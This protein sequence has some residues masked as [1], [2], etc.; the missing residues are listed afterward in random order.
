MINGS[1]TNLDTLQIDYLYD[2]NGVPYGG[3]Y[4]SPTDTGSPLFFAM[5]T[6][7]RSDVV[8][9]LDANGHPFAGY[10]YDA[11]GNPTGTSLISDVIT[12]GL[13]AAIANRQ[14]LRYASYVYDS[15]SGLYYLSARS[16]DPATAQF[17]SPDLAKADGEESAYQ[18]CG[19]EP[20]G[21]VDPTG[22]KGE[23]FAP[24]YFYDNTAYFKLV[25]RRDA[26]HA[27]LAL[28]YWGSLWWEYPGHQWDYKL[29]YG[30]TAAR[31]YTDCWYFLG[32]WISPDDFGNIHFGYICAEMWWPES[33][34][35]WFSKKENKHMPAWKEKQDEDFIR[36]GYQLH[37]YWGSD[38][39]WRWWHVQ[40]Y[41]P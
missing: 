12:P 1:P 40:Y 16:Y 2:E 32:H 23:R 34:M 15:E 30:S 17:I 7:D 38:M 27:R 19:G 36:W 26:G 11:W 3:L 24:K 8:E 37:H 20:V 4:R 31:K 18:Y 14:V 5:V 6:T 21:N 9:L 35:T 28:G 39:S 22:T 13:P 33:W 10:R 41:Y 25:L 29:F